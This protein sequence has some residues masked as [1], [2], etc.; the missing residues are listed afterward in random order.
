VPPDDTLYKPAC[1]VLYAGLTER[2]SSII[3]A[4]IYGHTH[5]DYFAL[6]YGPVSNQPV[7]N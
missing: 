5:T 7:G 1:A 4:H 6:I 3:L 2:Y